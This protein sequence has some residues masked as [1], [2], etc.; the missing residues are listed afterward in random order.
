[1]QTITIL[2]KKGGTAKTTTAGQLTA[3]L[4]LRG[5]NVLAV[6]LDSQRNLTAFLNASPDYLTSY[7]IL[8]GKDIKK[9]I[10]PTKYGDAI[11][12]SIELAGLRNVNERTL[13]GALKTQKK[14]DYIIIDTAPE[15]SPATINGIIAADKIVIA[16]QMDLSNY[17][18]INDLK[19][20]LDGIGRL[21]N[22]RIVIDGI[23][24]TR[25]KPRATI[26]KLFAEPYEAAAARMKTK[27]YE[28]KIRDCGALTM[29]QAMQQ[30]IYEWDKRSNAAADYNSFIDELITKGEK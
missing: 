23:L 14:Y 25:Y 5:Y 28:T 17:Q 21:Y 20:I 6:D 22:K 10:Q 24:I 12:G 15:I 18:G 26:S 19:S 27:I 8:T 3:G 16:A 7:D 4:T 2:S 29:A 1:M 13:A 9:A 11:A 30:S